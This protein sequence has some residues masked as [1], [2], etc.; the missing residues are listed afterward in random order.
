[1][2]VRWETERTGLRLVLGT[3]PLQIEVI[4]E[5]PKGTRNKYEATSRAPSAGSDAVHFHAVPRR[6]RLTCRRPWPRMATQWTPWSCSRADLPRMPHPRP[7]VGV[8]SCATRRESTPRSCAS[9]RRS[10]ART[11]SSSLGDLPEQRLRESPTSSR[12]T[13]FGAGKETQI[14]GW[15]TATRPKPRSGRGGAGMPP[16]PSPR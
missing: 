10:P 6:S 14:D 8:F 16:G 4:V 2:D 12:S 13:R 3:P 11:I 15:A 7:P 1:M 5:I 9:R